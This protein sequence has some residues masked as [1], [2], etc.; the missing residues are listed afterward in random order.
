MRTS[1]VFEI[2]GC[3]SAVGTS[4]LLIF[5]GVLMLWELLLCYIPGC[6]SAVGT[7]AVLIFLGVL[8]LWE[9]LLCLIFL[10]VLVL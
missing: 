2:P 1:A 7:S 9:L 6:A 5:L 10:G 3:A 8:V 4:A